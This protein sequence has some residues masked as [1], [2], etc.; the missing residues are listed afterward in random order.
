MAVMTVDNSFENSEE[1]R[2]KQK[3]QKRE[4]QQ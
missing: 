2:R 1:Q 3:K 4:A